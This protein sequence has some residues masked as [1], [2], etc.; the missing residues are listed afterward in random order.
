MLKII[1]AIIIVICGTA[2][3]ITSSNNLSSRVDFL[4]NFLKFIVFTE[5]EI[6]YSTDSLSNIISKFDSNGNFKKFLTICQNELK[7]DASF[8]DSWSSAIGEVS[9]N[10]KLSERDITIVKNFGQSLGTSDIES[11]SIHCQ[12]HKNLIND[13]ISDAREVKKNK[14]KLYVTLGICGSITLV[15]IL[16]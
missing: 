13:E 3:G 7:N 5:K 16:I 9:K 1:G 6:T 14:S 2:L 10:L 15:L 4:E 12:L 8:F 11:Q